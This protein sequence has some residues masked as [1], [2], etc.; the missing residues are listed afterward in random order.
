[1]CTPCLL[2][3][4]FTTPPLSRAPFLPFAQEQLFKE[5]SIHPLDKH[6]QLPDIGGAPDE[7]ESQ[8]E[9]DEEKFPADNDEANGTGS[10]SPMNDTEALN[11][12]DPLQVRGHLKRKISKSTI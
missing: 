5:N 12:R 3:K 4:S 6:D 11:K 1:M 7:S 8:N 2:A 10:M 9:P